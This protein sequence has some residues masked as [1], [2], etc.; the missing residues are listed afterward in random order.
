MQGIR[1]PTGQKSLSH[2][3]NSINHQK[4]FQKQNKR[5][6]NEQEAEPK[7]VCGMGVAFTNVRKLF[8]VSLID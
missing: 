1:S 7:T 8:V 2:G 4:L 5:N 3:S 6:T